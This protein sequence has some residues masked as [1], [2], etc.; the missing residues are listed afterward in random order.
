ML[1]CLEANPVSPKGALVSD[2]VVDPLRGD[3]EHKLSTL[4]WCP[5]KIHVAQELKAC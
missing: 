5:Q 1:P 2:T 3:P 4:P